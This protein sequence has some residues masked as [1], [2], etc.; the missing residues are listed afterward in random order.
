MGFQLETQ[1][2]FIIIYKG[3]LEPKTLLPFGIFGTLFLAI[4]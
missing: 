4:I 2:L 3:R 1:A